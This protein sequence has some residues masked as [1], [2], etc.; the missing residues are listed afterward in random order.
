MDG[1]MVARE[2]RESETISRHPN[3]QRGSIPLYGR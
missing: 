1:V 3:A 2:V